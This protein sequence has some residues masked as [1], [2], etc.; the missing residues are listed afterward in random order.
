MV[1]TLRAV[2]LPK[3]NTLI[4]KPTRQPCLYK[5]K[6]QNNYEEA[7]CNS[8]SGSDDYK[9]GEHLPDIHSTRVPRCRTYGIKIL[10]HKSVLLMATDITKNQEENLGASS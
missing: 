8:R 7:I 4:N 5:Q 1:G 2:S 3:G 6:H 9:P 10:V